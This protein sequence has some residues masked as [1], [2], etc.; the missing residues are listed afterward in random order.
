[1]GFKADR[2]KEVTCQDCGQTIDT[3]SVKPMTRT[4]C[5]KCG[6]EVPVPASFDHFLVYQRLGKGSFGHVFRAVD[7][8]LDREVAIKVLV[9][10]DDSDDKELAKEIITEA[11]TLASLN[12]HNIVKIHTLGEHR[13]QHY[14]VME[15]LD[16]GS[17]RKYLENRPEEEKVLDFAIGIVEGLRAAQ[18]VGLVH[19]DVKPGNVLFDRDGNAKVID[20]GTAQHERKHN[21]DKGVVGTP[22]YI[23]PEIA[24]GHAP[25]FKSD[26]YSL[27]A[28][29][30]H[31][32]AGKPPFLHQSVTETIKMR[33]TN[34][35]PDLRSVRPDV[36]RATSNVV[37]KMLATKP[38]DRFDSY[39]SLID[40]LQQAKE[41]VLHGEAPVEQEP[42]EAYDELAAL[43]QASSPASK[44]SGGASSRSISA[45]RP[46]PSATSSAI[47]VVSQKGKSNTPMLIAAGV[48]GVGILVAILLIAFGGGKDDGPKPAPRPSAGGGAASRPIASQPSDPQNPNSAT[49]N[50]TMVPPSATDPAPPVEIKPREEGL[51][52]RWT[53]NNHT[54][55]DTP[56]V[57][58]GEAS[59][60]V[61]YVDGLM[62]KAARFDGGAKDY[63]AVPDKAIDA[64]SGTIAMWFNAEALGDAMLF[65]SAA[66]PCSF[67][68][69][70]NADG[71]LSAK[72]GDQPID[73]SGSA[74]IEA[75]KWYH[76][77]LTWTGDGGKGK[78]ELFLDG[79][80]LGSVDVD[81]LVAPEH[82]TI[83]AYNRGESLA[84]RGLIDEARVYA[85]ALTPA[86]LAKLV[87]E[88][89]AELEKK[90]K[91]AVAVEEHPDAAKDIKGIEGLELIYDLDLSKLGPT[92]VYDVD[93]HEKFKGPFK[94]IGYLVELKKN[95][96]ELQYVF[97]AMDPF[98]DDLTKIGIPTAAS[99]AH[100]QTNVAALH[101]QSNVAG[102]RSA[103]NMN[104]GNIEFWSTNYGAQNSAKVPNASGTTYDFGDQ[105]SNS[106]NY[107]SMQVHNHNA[108]ETIFAINHWTQ[109]AE[110]GIGNNPRGNPD[111]TFTSNAGSYSYKRL[112][113]YVR[114][115]E[116]TK[117]VASNST[118]T[119]PE[120]EPTTPSKPQPVAPPKPEPAPY[121]DDPAATPLKDTRDLV[122]VVMGPVPLER[123]DNIGGNPNQ[124]LKDRIDKGVKP[125]KTAQVAK[126]EYRGAGDKFVVRIAG[127]LVPPQTGKY[128]FFVSADD[129]GSLR[130]STDADPA[131]IK[132]VAHKTKP[133]DE[134]ELEAGKPYYFEVYHNEGGGSA[135]VKVEWQ[136]PDAT[137][138]VI[139]KDHLASALKEQ[140]PAVTGFVPLQPV[141]AE[142]S[143]VAELAI[144]GDGAVLAGGRNVANETYS[145]TTETDLT[146]ISAL[147]LEAMTDSSLQAD[148]PGRIGGKFVIRDIEVTV[149]PKSDP[150][151]AVPVKFV[152]QHGF[153]GDKG[154]L[155]EMLDGDEKTYW[156]VERRPGKVT[157]ATFEPTHP[158]GYPGGTIITFK[159]HQFLNLGKLR[160]NA[161]T[162]RDVASVLDS[163]AG[164]VAGGDKTA[165]PEKGDKGKTT[166]AGTLSA[167]GKLTLYFNAGGPAVTDPQGR[168]WLKQQ[169]YKK[170]NLY[171]TV[172]GKTADAA[173]EPS[174][175]ELAEVVHTFWY[176]VGGCKFDVP[177][178]KYRVM[179]IFAE[180]REE[181]AGKRVF[182]V[183]IEGRPMIN[184][185]DIVK[186]ARG[187][188]RPFSTPW[189]PA[190][191]EDGVLDIEFKKVTGSPILNG[192]LIESVGAVSQ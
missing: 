88:G 62:Y 55:D 93:N 169:E 39:D 44:A 151:K 114:P 12:H 160:F 179:L 139:G 165:G 8:R 72:L 71:H 60:K 2:V 74:V 78:G 121:P 123:W 95:G 156:A 124:E 154:S 13:D 164:A 112:R 108:K 116:P 158:I 166:T 36:S 102:I 48:I 9:G 130:L 70:I 176:D 83:G 96:E 177:N 61:T 76:V 134:I 5:P 35:A 138:E 94:R 104:G 133:S 19:M 51:M 68:I 174:A 101:V 188:F 29:L 77:A 89:Q 82:A 80:S 190:V 161:T 45:V 49:N 187:K 23:A 171:G 117:A 6:A 137:R 42:A 64:K 173:G 33:L 178:G 131:N 111:W 189:L 136:R 1:M 109:D 53:F 140:P 144:Q 168:V 100:F 152:K 15:L 40:A 191:V 90:N 135:Y 14:I 155:A 186:E 142:A 86:D 22:Y 98:T 119:E 25:N 52:A 20:F 81:K 97:V 110:L 149:A 183:D 150:S 145:I 26:M 192:V 148:G 125:D 54:R 157:T 66:A 75:E 41:A 47:P 65:S 58:D 18:R 87:E 59:G 126:L 11:R 57:L 141:K 43:S 32:L 132:V 28:S 185:L 163:G 37:A 128:K 120:P 67:D 175:T 147:Q 181:L 46:K 50:I 63:V 85:R 146:F 107:G 103:S 24:R 31:I 115:G 34:P 3:S 184:N 153:A 106:G 113:V 10:D 143:N 30:F 170:G 182:T 180:M 127:Y 92:I 73:G 105:P 91:P 84:F 129:G 21:K 56:N 38:A 118:P 17:G 172:G 159:V 16:G 167:T 122:A 27:G 69:R 162:T 7:T 79:Q 99:K 4:T